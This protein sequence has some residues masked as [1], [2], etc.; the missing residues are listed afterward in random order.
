MSTA[1]IALHKCQKKKGA[2]RER[3]HWDM[4][5][6]RENI[7]KLYCPVQLKNVIAK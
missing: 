5:F 4:E 6:Y 1:L 7:N 3:E 2:V